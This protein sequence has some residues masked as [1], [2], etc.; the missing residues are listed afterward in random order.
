MASTK[1]PQVELNEL[2]QRNGW[3]LRY[4]DLQP[5]THWV[6]IQP[7]PI[8]EQRKH[9]LFKTIRC[10][11]A[12]QNWHRT[13][14]C[15]K[16]DTCVFAHSEDELRELP[17]DRSAQCWRMRLVVTTQDRTLEYENDHE[18]PSIREAKGALAQHC[19]SHL[20]R[21]STNPAV[22]DPV[23]TLSKT[24][25][26]RII[27]ICNG[28]CRAPFMQAAAQQGR[29]AW[30]VSLG[31]TLGSKHPDLIASIRGSPHGSWAAFALH[32]QKELQIPPEHELSDQGFSSMVQSDQTATVAH[33]HD[34]DLAVEYLIGRSAAG[35]HIG[36]YPP[37]PIIVAA[38]QADSDG[39]DVK[40]LKLQLD[41]LFAHAG[42]TIK[43]LR[44][45]LYL[46]SFPEHF[47][48][49]GD[50]AHSLRVFAR[51]Q[52]SD[53]SNDAF[54][55]LHRHPSAL[56][57]TLPAPVEEI[58]PSEPS[59]C[60]QSVAVAEPEYLDSSANSAR[61]P[62]EY[63]SLSDMNEQLRAR[64]H[65][66]EAQLEVMQ[67]KE[68]MHLCHI[69]MD[70]PQD[71]VLM[72]CLH[73]TFCSTCIERSASWTPGSESSTPI[74]SVSH[75]PTCRTPIHGVLKLRLGM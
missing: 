75:C 33:G 60:A 34:E 18:Y 71:V 47:R 46:Q 38:V 64:V 36:S 15:P 70:A 50:D 43:T 52:H 32:H 17:P 35:S 22:S 10:T 3:Q 58:L 61:A 72:P 1:L 5:S 2:C 56:P 26:K 65:D 23:A 6:P 55:P 21:S 63:E 37:H 49:E 4:D 53:M 12:E 40:E 68:E 44:L 57:Q 29:R 7:L 9:P 19:L 66:L 48:C 28:M 8:D 20:E 74:Y 69:C 16:G 27:A 62:S 67:A 45:S 13:G 14:G 39:L 25:V 54:P 41:E 59:A 30:L 51:L 11:A 24:Q 73:A 31:G 42:R